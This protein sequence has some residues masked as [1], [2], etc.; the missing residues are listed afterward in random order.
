MA[1]KLQEVYYYLRGVLNNHPRVTVCLLISFFDGVVVEARGVAICSV[2]DNF[3][4]KTGRSIA[5][6]RAQHALC[7]HDE[8]LPINRIDAKN[9]L[10]YASDPHEDIFKFK[11]D[12]LT[13]ALTEREKRIVNA[14]RRSA[15]KEQGTRF[16]DCVFIKGPKDA[17]V[18][19]EV[20]S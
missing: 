12:G 16:D 1:D 9:L 6:D 20:T 3:C 7:A 5:L 10:Y 15:H 4:K 2:R 13:P 8:D 18:K 11:S 14:I 17:T 19:V